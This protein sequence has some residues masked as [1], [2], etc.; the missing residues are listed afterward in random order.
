MKSFMY[1]QFTQPEIRFSE[2][3]P[4]HHLHTTPI[5]DDVLFADEK[6]FILVN[7]MIAISA[8]RAGCKILAFAI[9][10]NHLHF[11]IEGSQAECMAFFED[12]YAQ[13]YR[14]FRRYGKGDLVK[15]M[16]P[17]LTPITSLKQLRDEIAYVIR[18]PFV[19]RYDVNPFSFRWCS[20]F[21]YFN[22]MLDKGG[23]SAATLK[24]RA[25]R[26]FTRSRLLDEIDSRILVK[27]GVANPASFVDYERAMEFFDNARQFVMWVLK[28]VEGQVET[29]LKYGERPNLN[30]E[31]M[32]SITFKICK[33]VF[34]TN[35]P[36]DLPLEKKKQLALKLKNEYYGSNSQVAR[37]ANLPISVVDTMFPLSSRTTKN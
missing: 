1:Y 32:L 7:N 37:C 26:E 3:K 4:F 18:N 30:D 21:L 25:L 27:D 19:V 24:G 34:L 17:G 11:I 5:E 15:R 6:D 29:A 20:G 23:V 31:E 35:S 28:N 8:L 13:L 36:K 33:S 10:S 9:M 22:P 16:H 2:A 14:L 12:L